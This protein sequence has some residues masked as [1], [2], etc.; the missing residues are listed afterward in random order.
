MS[1]RAGFIGLGIMGS[2]MSRN[3]LSAGFDE[4]LVKP[5]SL[6][7]LTALLGHAPQGERLI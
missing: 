3:L 5:V 7:D 2:G 4:L 1:G 6:D